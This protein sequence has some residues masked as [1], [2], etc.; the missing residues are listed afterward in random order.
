MIFFRRFSTK[1]VKEISPYS[2][3]KINGGFNYKIKPF[4]LFECQDSNKLR[5]SFETPA[6]STEQLPKVQIT[7]NHVEL[8]DSGANKNLCCLL[9]VP[10]KSDL[11]VKTSQNVSISDLYSD[12]LDIEA[13]NV[14]TKN[15]HGTDIK[16]STNGGEISCTGLLLGKDIKFFLD[17]GDLTIDRIQGEKLVIKQNDGKINISSCYSTYSQFDCTNS[18]MNLKNIHKLCHIHAHGSGELTMH[19]FS[20]TLIADLDD[21]LMNLQFSEV[22]GRSKVTCKSDKPSTVNLASQILE[23][24]YVKLKAN[25]MN[26][27]EELTL[28]NLSTN[29]EHIRI[30]D[31]SFANHLRI[32]HSNEVLL[33]KLAWADAFNF[34]ENGEKFQLKDVK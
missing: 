17:S 20:G 22:L 34:G 19:G 8:T 7:D 4:D 27:D 28:L 13:K 12:L 11:T 6:E 1:I 3:I 25:R 2:K 18:V 31:K 5:V 21:Y 14:R 33:G 10:I 24:C 29:G 15:I 23:N 16:I 30:N 9:E 26:L 32:V